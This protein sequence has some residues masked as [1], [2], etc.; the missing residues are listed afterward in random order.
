M[1]H[2]YSVVDKPAIRRM[3]L[4]ALLRQPNPS[5]SLGSDTE[6]YTTESVMVAIQGALEEL[7]LS[8]YDLNGRPD[9]VHMFL[10]IVR[11]QE[12]RDL[13]DHK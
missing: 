5:N 2:I 7:E 11:H 12:I 3:F 4:R 9:H 13:C 10:S 1:W 6:S 8:A